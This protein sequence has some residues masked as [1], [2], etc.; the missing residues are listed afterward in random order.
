MKKGARFDE[1]AEKMRR[2]Y[3]TENKRLDREQAFV[4]GYRAGSLASEERAANPFVDRVLQRAWKRGYAFGK[5]GLK[6]M[7]KLP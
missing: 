5:K 1:T 2:K 3:A 7:L 6:V 4:F